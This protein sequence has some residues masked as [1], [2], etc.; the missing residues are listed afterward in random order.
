MESRRPLS[1][2][3]GRCDMWRRATSLHSYC[4]LLRCGRIVRWANDYGRRE[5]RFDNSL[6][7]SV[8]LRK[9]GKH[10]QPR[11][12]F[13]LKKTIDLACFFQ[14]KCETQDGTISL[15]SLIRSSENYVVKAKD[16]EFHINV[17]RPLV[18]KAYL[19]CLHGSA[20]CQVI[21]EVNG[22]FTNETVSLGLSRETQW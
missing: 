20:A 18:P 3:H 12:I 7:H 17:C 19:T 15:T 14:I 5:L 13:Y 6:E 9:K 16:T 4:F 22:Q 21:P 1:Q 8:S 11:K 10:R 2:L